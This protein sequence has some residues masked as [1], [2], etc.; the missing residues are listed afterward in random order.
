MV[1]VGGPCVVRVLG[2]CTTPGLAAGAGEGE[3]PGVG[4]SLP[5]APPRG[6]LPKTF[7]GADPCDAMVLIDAGLKVS[8]MNRTSSS[9]LGELHNFQV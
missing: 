3:I 2:V 7:T 9:S 8:G 5:R 6:M 4:G 1:P